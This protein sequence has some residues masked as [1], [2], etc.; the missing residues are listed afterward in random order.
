MEY[1]QEKLKDCLVE[2]AE[3]LPAHASEVLLYRDNLE[4]CPNFDV[5]MQLEEAGG[6]TI[7]TARWRTKLVGYVVYIQGPKPHYE[8][9]VFA[10]A[11]LVYVLPEYRK[12]WVG[13][14]LLKEG[15]KVLKN[16][17]VS[18]VLVGVTRDKDFS[19]VLEKLNYEA[20]EINMA[21]Y[22]GD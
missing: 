1:K 22:L 11:D 21:K 20:V 4:V 7:V 14:N 16:I 2:I 8:N 13:I 10:T 19:R 15:E 18:V 5:Y 6:L 9:T 12:G 17:G 3:L